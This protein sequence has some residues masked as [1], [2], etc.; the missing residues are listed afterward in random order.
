M[1]RNRGAK[2]RT[3]SDLAALA[4]RLPDDGDLADVVLSLLHPED[5]FPMGPDRTCAIVGGAAVEHE[6]RNAIT[7][8]FTDGLSAADAEAI[9]SNDGSAAGTLSTLDDRINIA[10]A[11][12]IVSAE[13]RA[14]L[15]QLKLIRNIFAHAVMPVS[16]AD[17]AVSEA[18]ALIQRARRDPLGSEDRNALSPLFRYVVVCALFCID[19]RDYQPPHR[20]GLF[21]G[22]YANALLGTGLSVDPTDQ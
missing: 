20:R 7:R 22:Q 8:H 16:F 15:K 18:M 21:G 2:S 19:F 11:L 6:L 12:G 17:G 3:R 1:A 9:F 10:F 14:E 5:R 4:K 13:V